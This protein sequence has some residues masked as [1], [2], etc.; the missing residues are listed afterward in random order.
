MP[1]APAPHNPVLL[2]AAPVSRKRTSERACETITGRAVPTVADQ[3]ADEISWWVESRTGRH[4]AV[5]DALV[6]RIVDL[7]RQG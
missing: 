7:A 1:S 3:V 5:P 6:Q 2:P 4:L